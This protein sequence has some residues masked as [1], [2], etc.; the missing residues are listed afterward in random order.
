[1]MYKFQRDSLCEK[2]G[3]YLGEIRWCA[4]RAAMNITIIADS[5]FEGLQS[6]SSST[7]MSSCV[8]M[9]IVD[10]RELLGTKRYQKGTHVVILTTD[11]YISQEWMYITSYCKHQTDPPLCSFLLMCA[12]ELQ[13]NFEISNIEHTS[14]TQ[15]AKH[16]DL[17]PRLVLLYTISNSS[18]YTCRLSLQCFQANSHTYFV[19]VLYLG[20]TM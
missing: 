14:T 11:V 7:K 12:A 1:M 4:D 15:S 5:Y 6:P 20:M 19:D 18:S 9:T 2:R 13:L 3:D 8:F 17:P 16:I 10:G